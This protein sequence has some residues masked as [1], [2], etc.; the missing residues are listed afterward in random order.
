MGVGQPS[1]SPFRWHSECDE[2]LLNLTTNTDKSHI[3][4]TILRPSLFMQD[5]SKSPHFAP[6]IS[7]EDRFYQLG[8]ASGPN[9]T[10]G[11]FT[12]SYR[13]AQ[14]DARDIAAVASYVLSEPVSRHAGNTYILNGPRALLW[15]D[16][17]TAISKA[18][19]RPIK[20]AM[21]SDIDIST[22]SLETDTCT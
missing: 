17:A 1:N 15:G 4:V 18:I 10:P 7:S 16:I 9:E 2:Q 12:D 3:S 20:A 8:K 11:S 19:G 6:V 21:L 5:M 13:I 22:N 14:V